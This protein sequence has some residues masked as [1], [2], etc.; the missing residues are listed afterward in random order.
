MK[1]GATIGATGATWNFF[2][3]KAPIYEGCN[4]LSPSL[5][6]KVAPILTHKKEKK[7]KNNEADN[8]IDRTILF[9]V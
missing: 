5:E 3:S 9:R 2:L 8:Y 6:G 7:E 1:L 4:I